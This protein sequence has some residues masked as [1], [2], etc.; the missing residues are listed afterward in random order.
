MGFL[1]HVM[2]MT[3]CPVHVDLNSC[4]H[5]SFLV[6]ANFD[7]FL[8]VCV[9]VLETCCKLENYTSITYV[10]YFYSTFRVVKTISDLSLTHILTLTRIE[11]ATFHS[12]LVSEKKEK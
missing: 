11:Q 9:C 10:M 6:K 8:Y 1:L 4:G 7:S 3:L 5:K 2:A 12:S